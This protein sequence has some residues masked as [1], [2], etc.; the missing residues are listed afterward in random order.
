MLVA[1]YLLYI[2]CQTIFSPTFFFFISYIMEAIHTIWE[3]E[4][5]FSFS[6][7]F[8]A[9][10]GC[11]GI[12]RILHP[13]VMEP[14]YDYYP[15]ADKEEGWPPA[16]FPGGGCI[17]RHIHIQK[18]K[19]NAKMRIAQVYWEWKGNSDILWWFPLFWLAP[20]WKVQIRPCCK[21]SSTGALVPGVKWQSHGMVYRVRPF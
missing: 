6:F 3:W 17:Y 15:G 16:R 8:H 11:M 19:K 18:K 9:K 13:Q 4:L 12:S 10:G 7:F 1:L 20:L 2:N 14:W 5:L 21:C